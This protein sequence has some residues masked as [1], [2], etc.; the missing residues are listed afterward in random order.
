[1]NTNSI[2]KV[3]KYNQ[4]GDI[5]HEYGALR[6]M[7]NDKQEITDF[8]TTQI[9]VS[10]NNSV[11][12][13]CQPSYDG[14]VNLII[15]D[16]TNY[17]RIVNSRIS[18]TENNRYRVVTRNQVEQTNLYS[19]ND[20]DAK[21]RLFRN[22]RKIPQINLRGVSHYG[23][24]KGGNYTFYVKFAD[25]DYNKTD[26]VC[27]SGIVSIFKGSQSDLQ[28]IS[29]TLSDELTDKTIDLIITNIDTTFSKVYLY[30]VRSTS[31][32]HGIRSD[33]FYA[34]QQPYDIKGDTLSISLN[35]YEEVTEINQEEL[36]IRYNLCTAVKTQTQ[37]QNMLFFGNVQGVTLNNKDLQ[38]ISLY[39]PVTL[40]QETKTIGFVESNY[41]SKTSD[42]IDQNEYYNPMNIYYKLGYWPGEIY[43][44]GIVYQMIDDSLSPVYNLRG[45]RFSAINES[46]FIPSL[47]SDNVVDYSSLLNLNGDMNYIPQDDFIEDSEYL[48]NT[49]G[50]FRNPDVNVIDYTSKEVLPLYYEIQVTE[51]IQ[52]IL[53]KYGVKGY[54][55]VRQKRIPITLCQGLSI[56]VDR[57]SFT[58]MLY[59]NAINSY[60][61]ESFIDKNGVLSTGYSGRKITTDFKQVSGLLSV[62]ASTNPILQ[63]IFDGTN[64]TLQRVTT[65]TLIA[66]KSRMYEVIS[67]N[68]DN[69]NVLTKASTVYINSDVPL[70]YI[71]NLGFSTRAGSAE[72]PKGIAFFSNREYGK[73]IIVNGRKQ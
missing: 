40:R 34:I 9:G 52:T 68:Y 47:P 61:S 21:T 53:K 63:S 51:E 17:P 67:S 42:D 10:L 50:V 59:E 60:I 4:E 19:S 69:D 8:R 73:E 33:Y 24:L 20:V 41:K 23:R 31:D 25:N 62:E 1:M 12:I 54:F 44:F 66:G 22:V 56:G 26:I 7:L 5:A 48:N 16:D 6:N 70:K 46:N 30:Y 43:R 71:N 14:T 32:L 39:L 2:L 49:K 28:S 38:N 29:G 37:V 72:E 27:E 35:G 45:C 57:V 55:I 3:K 18:R 65:G 36:N 58:P 13:E 11:N 15:N 64:Y